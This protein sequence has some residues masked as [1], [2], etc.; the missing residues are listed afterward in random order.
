MKVL[1]ALSVFMASE[2][3]RE[4]LMRFFRYLDIAVES[5]QF[6][7]TIAGG[8]DIHGLILV[9]PENVRDWQSQRA[10]KSKNPGTGSPHGY[11][12]DLFENKVHRRTLQVKIKSGLGG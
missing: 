3:I 2:I 9:E 6:V 7:A 5:E 12:E 4:K 11:V 1:I 8:Y 10:L